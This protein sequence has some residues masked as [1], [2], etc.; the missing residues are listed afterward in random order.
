MNRESLN[1]VRHTAMRSSINLSIDHQE[2]DINIARKVYDE[3]FF[4]TTRRRPSAEDDSSNKKYYLQVVHRKLALCSCSWN[5]FISFLARLMPIIRWLPKYNVKEDL[6]RD[7]SGGVTLTI[8]H[9][10]QGERSVE[11]KCYGS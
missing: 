11:I 10:P 2:P 7:T 6:L 9:I 3:T 5:G 8:M 4:T 1:T